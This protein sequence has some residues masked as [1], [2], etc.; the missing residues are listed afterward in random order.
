MLAGPFCHRSLRSI[1]MD[2]VG[3][4]LIIACVAIACDNLSSLSY[5]AHCCC[6]II[7]LQV[8]AKPEILRYAQY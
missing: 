4:V 1:I 2:R 7:H 5:K 8:E 3:N 6:T